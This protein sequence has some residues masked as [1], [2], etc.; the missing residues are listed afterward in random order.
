MTGRSRMRIFLIV[1]G[2]I[3]VATLAAML[4]NLATVDSRSFA[5]AIGPVHGFVWLAIV[6]SCLLTPWLT[7]RQRGL[8]A[9]PVVG[10]LL[11]AGILRTHSHQHQRPEGPPRVE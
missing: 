11:A 3:E 4:V 1:A 10:G 5:S 7:P 9:I 8:A 6:A 2:T